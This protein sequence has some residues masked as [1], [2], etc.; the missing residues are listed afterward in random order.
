M[1]VRKSKSAWLLAAGA[2]FALSVTVLNSCSSDEDYDMYMGDEL[3]THAAATRSASAENDG[4]VLFYG[5]PVCA[6]SYSDE[7]ATV[8]D[9]FIVDFVLAWTRGW[10]G[11]LKQNRSKIDVRISPVYAEGTA[12]NRVVVPANP[13][14][15]VLLYDMYYVRNASAEW[16]S[17]NG[18]KMTFKYNRSHYKFANYTS[19]LLGSKDTVFTKYYTREQL[20]C[21]VDSTLFGTN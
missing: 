9:S 16:T 12:V 15:N 21:Q 4:T 2:I 20:G 13:C 7:R 8:A 19:M 1:K 10:T 18:V 6:S 11:N 14:Y 17:S 5:I 3:S